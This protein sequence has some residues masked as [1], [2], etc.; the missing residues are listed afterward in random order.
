M[1]LERYDAPRLDDF[2]LRFLDLAGTVRRMGVA[3]REYDLGPLNLHDKKAQEWL[4]R[5]EDWAQEANAQ[6]ETNIIKKKAM[7]R[8]LRSSEGARPTPAAKKTR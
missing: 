7:V 5:L 4:T 3:C 6:V 2:A 8:A 1:T